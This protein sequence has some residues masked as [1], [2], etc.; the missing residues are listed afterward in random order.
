MANT[1]WILQ[2]VLANLQHKN[3]A[4]SKFV[5]DWEE[6]VSKAKPFYTIAQQRYRN[7]LI[8]TVGLLL[9]INWE[10]RFSLKRSFNFLWGCLRSYRLA[11]LVLLQ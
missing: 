7:M 4:V 11:G 9:T 3:P 10:I 6:Q 8:S 5:G 1:L 2:A